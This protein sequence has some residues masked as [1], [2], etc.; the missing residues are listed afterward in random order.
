MPRCQDPHPKAT[1]GVAPEKTLPLTHL[2]QTPQLMAMIKRG[3]IIYKTNKMDS[4][5]SLSLTLITSE[6]KPHA[7]YVSLGELSYQASF[8]HSQQQ[9]ARSNS[10][11]ER[12]NVGI[13]LRER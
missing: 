3:A 7:R 2:A 9:R 13:L 12:G 8:P 5:N 6:S 4:T 1:M 11:L 10:T